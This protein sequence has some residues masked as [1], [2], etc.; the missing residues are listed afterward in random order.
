MKNRGQA[1]MEFLMTY[2]WAILSAIIVIAVIAI[3]FKPSSIVGQASIFSPPFTALSQSIASGT[4]V[5]DVEIRNSGASTATI[6]AATDVVMTVNS[7]SGNPTCVALTSGLS[8]S[9][10]SW[11]ALS[12]AAPGYI[13]NAGQTLFFRCTFAA[14]ILTKGQSFNA[15][16]SITYKGGTGSIPLIATGTVSGKIN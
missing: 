6:V 12:Y 16:V 15:D 7:P 3:Y 4:Q 14:G 9:V 2:G 8:T 10:T 13:W 5:V 1:A 11:G